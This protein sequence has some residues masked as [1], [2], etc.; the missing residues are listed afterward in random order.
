L[1]LYCSETLI[2]KK[3]ILF[4]SAMVYD[5]SFPS[6]IPSNR[7]GSNVLALTHWYLHTNTH[8]L[9]HTDTKCA[10]VVVVAVAAPLYSCCSN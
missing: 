6:T 2:E 3:V 9:R 10:F 4:L 5:R 7:F 1:Y 8:T